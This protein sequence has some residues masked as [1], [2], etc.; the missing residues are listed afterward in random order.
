[1]RYDDKGNLL[2]VYGPNAGKPIDVLA[3]VGTSRA[4]TLTSPV[5]S[6]VKS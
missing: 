4:T 2:A 6:Q 3:P 5:L 1:M